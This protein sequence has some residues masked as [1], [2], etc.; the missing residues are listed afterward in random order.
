MMMH[1]SELSPTLRFADRASDYALFRPSYP[2]TA[3][4]AAL[5]GLP[6]DRPL[7]AADIGAGTGISAR[8][9][10]DRGLTVFAVEPNEAMR[11]SAE[12]HEGVTFVEGTAEATGLETASMDLISCA[13]AFHWFRPQEAL[14]EFDRILRPRGRIVLL[15]NER[16]NA[17]E[18]TRAYNAAIRTAADR[19][20]SEGMSAAIDDALREAGRKT[21]PRSFP[22]AQSLSRDGLVGRA[23]SAS[24]VPKD[25]PRHVQL[26]ADLD[27]LWISHHDA[28]GLVTLGYRTFLWIVESQA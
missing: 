13:Q 28:A 22:Y 26:A 3:I 8:L 7:V 5:E 6:T 24:Y 4:D 9:F 21:S 18:T 25:G 17:H 19:E 20:L 2:A 1:R 11:A 27:A 12:A 23:Q 16:D 10:A 15:V 14:H